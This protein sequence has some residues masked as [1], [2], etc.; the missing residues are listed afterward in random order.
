MTKIL[1]KHWKLSI[2][3]RLP[4]SYQVRRIILL[5]VDRN[6]EAFKEQRA[7]MMALIWGQDKMNGSQRGARRLVMEVREREKGNLKAIKY[8]AVAKIHWCVLSVN[9]APKRWMHCCKFTKPTKLLNM[10]ISDIRI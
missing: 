4:R 3:C 6:M 8:L 1:P 5:E 10:N 2:P 9:I 7:L